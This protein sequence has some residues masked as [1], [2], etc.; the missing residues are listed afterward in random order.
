M[1]QT[2]GASLSEYREF[3]AVAVLFLGVVAAQVARHLSGRGLEKL[4]EWMAQSSTSDGGFIS[5]G[6]IRTSRNIVFWLVV[7]VAVTLALRLLGVGGF[8]AIQ[9][10]VADYLPR[11]V[12]GITIL[13]VGHVMGLLGRGLLSRVSDRMQ[14]DS[15]VP[16]LLHGST[17]LVAALMALQ[18]MGINISF[19]TQLILVLLGIGSGGLVLAFALGAKQHVANL[20][21]RSD[22]RRYSVGERIRID[23]HEG[24]IVAIHDTGIQLATAEGVVSIPA[25]RVSQTAVTTLTGGEGR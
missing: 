19:L 15:T 1:E 8:T 9:Q 4:D 7:A 12:I 17:L 18:Q 16:R 5:P 11:L 13:G 25:A 21:A 10:D 6:L 3:I 23:D 20:V 24:E 22:L 14:P 2:L